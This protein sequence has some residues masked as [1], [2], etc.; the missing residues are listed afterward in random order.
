MYI[1]VA[2]QKDR[3]HALAQQRIETKDGKGKLKSKVCAR[4]AWRSVATRAVSWYH[5][6]GIVFEILR[7]SFLIFSSIWLCK[8]LEQILQRRRQGVRRQ[9]R[10]E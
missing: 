6:K 8:L 2:K 1:Q 7:Y 10:I 5:A 3:H 4:S 9:Q